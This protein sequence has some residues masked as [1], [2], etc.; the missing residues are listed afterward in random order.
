[1]SRPAGREAAQIMVASFAHKT[2]EESIELNFSGVKAIGLSWLHE[3]GLGLQSN[4]KN[5]IGM[6]DCG[7]ASVIESLKFVDLAQ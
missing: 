6:L 7:N 3:I 2:E 1:M 5:R 4:F